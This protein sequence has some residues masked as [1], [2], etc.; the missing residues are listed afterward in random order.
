VSSVKKERP[1]FDTIRWVLLGG[2]VGL[3]IFLAH[4]LLSHDP[5]AEIDDHASFSNANQDP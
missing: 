4:L 2:L 5:E 1:F 3:L